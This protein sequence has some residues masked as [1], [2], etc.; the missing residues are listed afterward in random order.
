MKYQLQHFLMTAVLLLTCTVTVS[1]EQPS[2]RDRADELYR[3]YEYANA[4][5]L[6]TRL[7][8]SRRPRLADLERLADCY[9]RMNDYEAAENWYAREVA[10]EGS[11]AEN[12]LRYGE[13]L[14][15]NAK[16]AEPK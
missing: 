5:A 1:Q 6:Y 8:D 14:T 13:V 15:M 7:A 9:A 2:L 12:L 16:Y 10:M 4:A 11:R 3:K